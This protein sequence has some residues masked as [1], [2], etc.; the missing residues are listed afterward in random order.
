MSST[1]LRT[2]TEPALY[3]ICG[4]APAGKTI[5]GQLAVSYPRLEP[6]HDQIRLFELCPN[7]EKPGV[8]GCFRIVELSHC[9]TYIAVSSMW[10]DQ[11]DRIPVQVSDVHNI[12][13][14]QNLWHFLRLQASVITQPTLFW[15]DSI[16]INQ[17]SVQERNH[18]V[19][20]MKDVYANAERVFVWLG[21]KLIRAMML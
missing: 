9:P 20:M 2:I 5:T 4:I 7:Q 15:V 21:K 16:C 10:E 17:S 14:G 12:N 18:Q 11:T 19:G 3:P 8:R 13:V 1:D 6:Q